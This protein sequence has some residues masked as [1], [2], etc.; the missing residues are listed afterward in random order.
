MMISLETLFRARAVFSDAVL[1]DFGRSL[2]EDV[3]DPI[4]DELRALELFDEEA[5]QI[6][7]RVNKRVAE[8]AR[9]E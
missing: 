1:D 3:F 8:A 4:A 2:L 7:D 9:I 6:L 5:Q